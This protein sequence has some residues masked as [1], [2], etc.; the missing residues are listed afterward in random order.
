MRDADQ[1]S[2]F[3]GAA[4]LKPV[5]TKKIDFSRND[6]QSPNQPS[7]PPVLVPESPVENGTVEN[8]AKENGGLAEVSPEM[9]G[10]GIHGQASGS[11][12]VV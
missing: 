6:H 4:P 8:K 5:D 7:Q 11:S 1:L 10:T 9:N 2:L 12:I 3:P